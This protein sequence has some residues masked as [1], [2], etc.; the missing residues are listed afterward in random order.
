MR[1]CLKRGA[2]WRLFVRDTVEQHL[3]ESHDMT[4][5]GMAFVQATGIDW[6]KYEQAMEAIYANTL[7][8]D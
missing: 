3:L 4:A 7:R 2:G 5:V 6:K 8:R 1:D